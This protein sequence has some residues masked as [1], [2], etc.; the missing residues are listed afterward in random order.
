MG[1]TGRPPVLFGVGFCVLQVLVA[2]VRFGS[3]D[4][5]NPEELLFAIPALFSGLVLFFLGGVLVGLLVQRLLRGVC[6]SLAE[7]FY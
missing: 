1:V 3:M 2:L 6:R 4:S 7:R 5:W